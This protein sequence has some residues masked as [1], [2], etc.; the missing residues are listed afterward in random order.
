MNCFYLLHKSAGPEGMSDYLPSDLTF[1]PAAEKEVGANAIKASVLDRS[2]PLR[3]FAITRGDENR[4]QVAGMRFNPPAFLPN[5]VLEL[6]V[7]S[8]PLPKAG[9]R[10]RTGRFSYI[11]PDPRCFGGRRGNQ[12]VHSPSSVAPMSGRR[13]N[14]YASRS[15]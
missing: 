12:H 3:H 9:G 7:V 13:S 6:S 1:P 14:S 5:Y 4:I 11:S 8:P 15:K 2:L 10:P